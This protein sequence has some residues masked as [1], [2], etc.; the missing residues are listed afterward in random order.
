MHFLRVK[1]H[2]NPPHLRGTVA[3]LLTIGVAGC[4]PVAQMPR[5]GELNVVATAI[6]RA[7]LPTNLMA[8]VRPDTAGTG[9][10]GADVSLKLNGDAVDYA[11]VIRNPAGLAI[12]EA[13]VVMSADGPSLER[14]VAALFVDGRFRDRHLEL[15]GTV[16]ILPSLTAAT[17]AEELQ[18]RPGAFRVLIRGRGADGVRWEGGLRSAH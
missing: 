17:L 7:S 6:R 11:M 8:R 18:I 13:L 3:A 16:Q 1:W 15:R 12:E 10:V 9:D 2:P 14:V 5:A 4:R